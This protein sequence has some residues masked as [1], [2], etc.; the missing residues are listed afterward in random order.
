MSSNFSVAVFPERI[1]SGKDQGL[2]EVFVAETVACSTYVGM[3]A[4]FLQAKYA[5]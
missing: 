4:P 5:A 1:D 2:S 3:H